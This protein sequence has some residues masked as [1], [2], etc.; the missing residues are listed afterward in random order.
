M[1][2]SKLASLIVAMLCAW[3]GVEH[4]QGALSRLVVLCLPWFCVEPHTFDE[5]NLS[6]LFCAFHGFVLA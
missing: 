5:L 6:L 3:G 2:L 1:T 4:S